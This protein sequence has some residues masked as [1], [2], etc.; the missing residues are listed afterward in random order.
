MRR[1]P[2]STRTDTLF[3]YTTLFRSLDAAPPPAEPVLGAVAAELLPIGVTGTDLAALVAGWEELLEPELDDEGLM[4]HARERGGRL[5]TL[6][7]RIV[8]MDR[9]ALTPAG[10]GWA[11]A[12]LA[13]HVGGPMLNERA[14]PLAPVPGSALCRGWGC[15]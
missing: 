4:R 5:F 12:D 11:R 6:A 14:S 15:W 9:P 1:P 7:G 13:L 10:D 8:G 2:R 3:P